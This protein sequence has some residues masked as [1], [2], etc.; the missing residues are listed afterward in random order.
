MER[1]DSS[2][3]FFLVVNLIPYN[4]KK[5]KQNNKVVRI[6]DYSISFFALK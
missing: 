3:L 2:V 5:I 4:N 1:N 6:F